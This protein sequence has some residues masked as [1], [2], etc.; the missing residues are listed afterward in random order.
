MQE[1]S[2][3][4]VPALV[5]ANAAPHEPEQFKKPVNVDEAS[6]NEPETT[7]FT[8]TEPEPV[9]I[10]TPLKEQEFISKAPDAPIAMKAE[11]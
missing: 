10:M 1:V 6:A 3:V 9:P 11:A 5:S 7:L 8:Y 2:V 4:E